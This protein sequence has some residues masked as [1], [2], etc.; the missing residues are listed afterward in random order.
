MKNPT[1]LDRESLIKMHSM[2]RVKDA[3]YCPVVLYYP[4]F[5]N[6]ELKKNFKLFYNRLENAYA[7]TIEKS[8]VL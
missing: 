7:K 2:Y 3:P 1:G 8:Q 6:K 4:Y 5:G